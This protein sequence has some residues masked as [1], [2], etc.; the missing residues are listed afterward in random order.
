MNQSFTFF[1]E[2][3]TQVS[4]KGSDILNTVTQLNYRYDDIPYLIFPDW[5]KWRT[6]VPI[7]DPVILMRLK[8]VMRLTEKREVVRLKIPEEARKT[9][10]TSSENKFKNEQIVLQL[11]DI[12]YDAPVGITYLLFVNLPDSE[13]NP[14]HTHPRFV[15][16]LG[17]FGSSDSVGGGHH[18]DMKGGFSEEYDITRV[19]KTLGAIHNF[20]I[21]V[22]PSLPKAPAGRKDLQ[23]MISRMKPHGNPRIGEIVILRHRLE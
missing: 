3:G 15:G 2:N 12:H 20:T 5:V 22:I 4:L 1:D 7:G 9:L 14:N 6:F 21:T 18:Q 23:E 16:T 13:R 10:A 17:F 11:N 19:L 8:Q